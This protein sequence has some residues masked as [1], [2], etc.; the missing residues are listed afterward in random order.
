MSLRDTGDHHHIGI[1]A[2]AGSRYNCCAETS[3]VK[4]TDG[5]PSGALHEIKRKP[6]LHCLYCC[7]YFSECGCDLLNC[8]CDVAD[9]ACRHPLDSCPKQQFKSF[10]DSDF[11]SKIKYP[12]QPRPE[13]YLLSVPLPLHQDPKVRERAGPQ[14]HRLTKSREFSSSPR[15]LTTVNVLSL[16]ATV[17]TVLQAPVTK[18]SSV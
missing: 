10:E 15:Q 3:P 18:R 9:S 8:R 5:I 6:Y 7:I 14:P 13:P 11:T 17:R 1:N 4:Y 2:P 16:L 12:K